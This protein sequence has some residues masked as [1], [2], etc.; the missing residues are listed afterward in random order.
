MSFKP[1]PFESLGAV[2]YSPS[3]NY[4]SILHHLRNKATYWTKI[5]I[6]FI[7]PCIR[8][9]R[10]GVPVGILPSRL[11]WKNQNNGVPDGEKFLRICITVYTQ[12]RH[13]ADRQTDRQTS[14]HGI[15]CAMH[16]HRTVKTSAKK[17]KHNILTRQTQNRRLLKYAQKTQT[18]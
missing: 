1:V 4:G 8:C 11:V 10:Q 17:L 18:I 6:F 7:P 16:T 2:S 15:V 3:S 13:V 14:F 5:V 9:P 12:Y